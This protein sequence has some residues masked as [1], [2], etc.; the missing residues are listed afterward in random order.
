[1]GVPSVRKILNSS[2]ISCAPHASFQMSAGSMAEEFY[3]IAVW[4]NEVMSW[5]ASVLSAT[6]KSLPSVSCAS[7]R[8]ACR[9]ACTLA[10]TS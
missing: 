1:M 4:C 8:T 5:V 2:S 7:A 3:T 6:Y 10:N 9:D